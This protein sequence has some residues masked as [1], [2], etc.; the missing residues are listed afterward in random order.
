[1]KNS[2]KI[3]IDYYIGEEYLFSFAQFT[4]EPSDKYI[5]NEDSII[6][7]AYINGNR[8]TVV[9]SADNEE[10]NI[11]WNDSEYSYHI[12]STQCDVDTLLKYAESVK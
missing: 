4:L 5:D 9:E 8:V 7:Y 12:F 3:L 1:M 11:L 6:S 10:I 2:A